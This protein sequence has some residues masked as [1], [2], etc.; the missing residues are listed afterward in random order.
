MARGPGVKIAIASKSFDTA[1]APVFSNFVLDVAPSSVL[2]LVGPSGVGKST[3]LRLI[4]GI[5]SN[6][7][8]TITIAGTPAA[9]AP[10][11]GFVFQ[12]ARILPWLTALDNVRIARPDMASAEAEAALQRVGLAGFEHAFPHQLSGGMQRRVALAR[13][14]SVNPQLLLL[15]EPFVSLDRT[16]VHEV[17]QVLLDLIGLNEPTVILVTHLVEDAAKLADRA[18]VLSGRPA[19]IAADISFDVPRAQRD[20]AARTA[21]ETQLEV[22]LAATAPA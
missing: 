22:A 19:V 5:D 7:A 18:V 17:E 21:I 16:L 14:F 8:G 1:H 15:D 20:R 10:P 2:A 6:F 13:S 9:D 3:L 4:A 11:P 12:D